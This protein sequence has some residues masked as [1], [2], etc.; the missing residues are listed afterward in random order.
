MANYVTAMPN[1]I[2]LE[3]EYEV[4]LVEMSYTYSW[5]NVPSGE[6]LKFYDEKDSLIAEI[7]M[8]HG[9]YPS[10]EIIVEKI[11][12]D[13]AKRFETMTKPYHTWPHLHYDHIFRKVIELPG[14]EKASDTYRIRF[15]MSGWMS[16]VLGLPV[17]DRQTGK[18]IKGTENRHPNLNGGIQSIYVYTDI[19][20]HSIVGDSLSQVLRVVDGPQ[21]ENF[22]EEVVARYVKPYYMPVQSKEFQ[23]IE[24]LLKDNLGELIRFNYGSVFIVLHFRKRTDNE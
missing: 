13:V 19:V 7:E 17:F 12:K 14:R 18:I 8:K 4:A 9:V 6:K 3:E 1:N 20:A 2:I 15:N 22:G 23:K 16:N 21:K 5:Y 11:N 24:I 10:I